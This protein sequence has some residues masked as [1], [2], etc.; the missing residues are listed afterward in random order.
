MAIQS[1]EQAEI[2]DRLLS[3]R[4][5]FAEQSF[6]NAQA[7]NRAIDQKANYLIAAVGILTTAL[8]ILASGALSARLSLE[9]PGVLKA[10]ALLLVLAYLLTAFGV[11]YPAAQVYRAL[12]NVLHP[13]TAAPGLL[14]P[15][16]IVSRF[17]SEGKPDERKYFN[18]LSTATEGELLYDYANQIV[19]VSNIY[20]HKHTQI[21]R[22][23]ERFRWLSV[24]WLA[25]AMLLMLTILLVPSG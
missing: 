20:R 6:N 15:L 23:I 7:L 3:T 22:S 2:D 4:H 16:M 11:V 13:N 12:A 14:F 1:D 25:T 21:N 19:E 10:A 8:G 9:W 18:R 24:L 5:R 17:V